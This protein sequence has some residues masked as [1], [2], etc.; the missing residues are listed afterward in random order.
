[1]QPIKEKLLSVARGGGGAAA[2]LQ[3]LLS[4]LLVIAINTTT[5]IITARLLAPEGRGE[6]A[7][8]I[9]WPLFWAN[10]LTLGV[11]SALVFN[12]RRRPEQ[13]AQ[14]VAGALA[15]GSGLS[16][17]AVL[18]GV[19][20]MPR[21]LA[22]YSGEIVQAAR[23]L[24]WHAPIC[25]FILIGRA[26]FEARGDFR[27]SNAT[28]FGSSLL[29]L[30][31][32]G[33]LAATD[34]LTPWRAALSYTLNSVPVALW[35]LL[36]LWR[37]FKPQW[38]A[39]GAAWRALLRYGVRAYGAELVNAMSLQLDQ[40]LVVGLLNPAAM[41]TYVVAVSLARMLQLFQQAIVMVLFPKAAGRPA[42]E[43][44]ALTGRAARL[45]ALVTVAG[46]LGVMLA[47]Q[48][49]LRLFYGAEFVAATNLLRLLTLETIIT[50]TTLVL[51]QA[52]MALGKP[53]TVTLLQ[54]VGL[55]LS[56]GL[57]LVLI[58][59]FGLLGAGL[60]LVCSAIVRLGLMMLSFPWL[61]K[62]RA[63]QLVLQRE[64][65]VFLRERLVKA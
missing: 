37:T 8:L 51:A 36:R 25:I 55:G 39:C 63:P 54:G 50:S 20:L 47:G 15:L 1:M 61:L 35:V 23:L 7:A 56:V 17:A 2:V 53:G 44:I 33:V 60:A 42:A 48:M 34:L 12:L 58:P 38:Q 5:G 45:S 40:V 29:G 43:V 30:I 64:D 32:L 9:L 65:W 22:Q 57:M 16:V 13:G 49:L 26:A 19:A 11:P 52:F 27:H 62:E 31:G 41:G 46:G 14:Y 59:R 4:K 10:A 24:L 21:F 18:V 6:L 28:L 3:S